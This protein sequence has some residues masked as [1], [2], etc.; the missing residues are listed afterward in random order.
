MS[1]L[2]LQHFSKLVVKLKPRLMGQGRA[3]APG[4]GPGTAQHL[5][6]PGWWARQKNTNLKGTRIPKM[7]ISTGNSPLSLHRGHWRHKRPAR[8]ACPC[9][10][11][12]GRVSEA[13]LLLLLL[14]STC[15]VPGL[16]GG[17][18]PGCSPCGTRPFCT[19][20]TPG[21]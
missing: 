16:R 18:Q 4:A 15:C 7:N 5:H 10:A 2:F 11:N 12:T 1:Q 14:L 21:L 8:M 9:G 19:L 13:L 6:P 3:R 17:L 20:G